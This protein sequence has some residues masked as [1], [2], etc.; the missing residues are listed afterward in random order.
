MSLIFVDTNIIAYARDQRDPLK[1]NVA[2]AW[3]AAL[4]R[5]RRG[6]LSWQVLIEFYAV[7]T[8]PRK[9]AMSDAAARAD[10][11]SLQA[12]QPIGPDIELLESAWTVQT[13]HA[14]SWW[15]AMII[16]AALKA[17]CSTLLSEDLQHGQV[18]DARL[19]IVNP[20]APDA[21]SPP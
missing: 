10:V 12:W 7:A 21:P 20:F 9:L 13:R 18:I 15:D 8:H 19:T 14:L 1:Q 11:S 3:L 2:I 16:A 6:R 4:A 5:Q 17:G